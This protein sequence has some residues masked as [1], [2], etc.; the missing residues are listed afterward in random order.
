[1]LIVKIT[2]FGC[3]IFVVMT[4]WQEMDPGGIA[5]LSRIRE[6]EVSTREIF[7]TEKRQYGYFE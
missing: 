7:E 6:F 2:S 5:A 3:K 1:M 4:E